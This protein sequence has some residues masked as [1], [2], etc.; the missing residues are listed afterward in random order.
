MDEKR[1]S[2]AVD[3]GVKRDDESN[4]GDTNQNRKRVKRDADNTNVQKGEASIR[5]LRPRRRDPEELLA[6]RH[7]E[8][9][10]EYY[11]NAAF[12]SMRD[13]EVFMFLQNDY[14]V[15]KY[16]PETPGNDCLV[17][18]P[19]L[20]C[21]GFPSLYSSGFSDYGTDAAFGCHGVN[22]A[23]LFSAIECAKIRYDLDTRTGDLIKVKAIRPTWTMFPC[24]GELESVVFDAAFE[25][26]VVHEAYLFQGSR[27]VLL[28]Y[29]KRKL[30]ASGL[31]TYA[32]PCL[33]DTIFSS[34]IG[35]AFASHKSNQVYLFKDKS[36]VLLHYNPC[37][38]DDSYIIDGPGEIVPVNWP[39]LRGIVPYNCWGRGDISP[40]TWKAGWTGDGWVKIA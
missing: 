40:K 10:M 22:E 29:S 32:F 14:F 13:N 25:S 28:N 2:T 8:K 26:T 1:R 39:S 19:L 16:D 31:I 38:P 9:Y 20:V 6:L 12:R 35:A 5:D 18:G 7:T 15:I 34:D 27:Y 3:K 36:Y 37:E 17:K 24:L 11:V 23:F 4:T 30:I 21:D 33:R